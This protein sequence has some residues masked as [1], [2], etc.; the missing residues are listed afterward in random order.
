MGNS[1]RLGEGIDMPCYDSRGDANTPE[2]RGELLRSF[3]HN[4]PLAE[5]LCSMCKLAESNGWSVSS[6]VT[7]WWHDH[8]LRDEARLKAEE[9]RKRRDD[10]AAVARAKLSPIERKVLGID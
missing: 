9:E 5:M 1:A 3:T 6:D 8:R 7:V 10:I 4:S 2:G